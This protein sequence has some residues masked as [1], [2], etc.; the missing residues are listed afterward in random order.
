MMIDASKNEGKDA[1]N[2][3]DRR[4]CA[5]SRQRAGNPAAEKRW[6]GHFRAGAASAAADAI[7]QARSQWRA[8]ATGAT[9]HAPSDPRIGEPTAR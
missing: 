4:R 9:W 7:P 6:R 3:C 8:V 2:T 1:D 5:G